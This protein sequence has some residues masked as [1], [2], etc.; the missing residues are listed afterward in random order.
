MDLIELIFKLIR[1][2][3]PIS[4]ESYGQLYNE[5]TD[6][7]SQAH[8][9]H[10]NGLLKAYARVHK[11]WGVRLALAVLYIPLTKLITTWKMG[12]QDPEE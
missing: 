1:V 2:H 9:E 5:A 3:V 4:Q 8:S 11:P 12:E 6:W 10:E 7:K